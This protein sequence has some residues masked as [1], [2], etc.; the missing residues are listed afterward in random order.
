VAEFNSYPKITLFGKTFI[1]FP[2]ENAEE[3]WSVFDHPVIRIYKK[4]SNVK[5]QMSKLEKKI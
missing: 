3:T 2:D 1:E 4:S 5:A